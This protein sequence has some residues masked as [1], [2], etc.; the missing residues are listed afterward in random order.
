MLWE[1]G[2]V[3]HI[4]GITIV[5]SVNSKINMQICGNIILLRYIWNTLY[6]L[7]RLDMIALAIAEYIV[8]LISCYLNMMLLI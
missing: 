4:I 2:M 5:E 6:Q 1:K 7:I 8:P 3:F